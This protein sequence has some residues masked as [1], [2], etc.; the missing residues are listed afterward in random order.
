MEANSTVTSVLAN[1]RFSGVSFPPQVD[2][3]IDQVVEAVTSSG[4]W[5]VVFSVLALLVAYD[6]SK[7]R[8]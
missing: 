3:A 2:Q 6:Q 4:P 5:A 1:A 8:R 7:T